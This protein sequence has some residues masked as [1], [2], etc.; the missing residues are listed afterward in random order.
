MYLKAL[1]DD[2][3]KIREY[4]EMLCDSRTTLID[5]RMFVNDLM[6][7]VQRIILPSQSA[8]PSSNELNAF[9]QS[10]CVRLQNNL[11]S[12]DMIPH[13]LQKIIEMLTQKRCS[14]ALLCSG[15]YL[16]DQLST[17]HSAAIFAHAN[18]I[19][20]LMQLF[21]HKKKYHIDL[22]NNSEVVQSSDQATYDRIETIDISFV[23]L[24]ILTNCSK[25]RSVLE[26][27][28]F[29]LF[30]WRT[31][32]N[33]AIP[34]LLCWLQNASFDC[35]HRVR[36]PLT[37]C[38]K[39]RF[40][41]FACSFFYLCFYFYFFDGAFNAD[42][43]YNTMCLTTLQY[44]CNELD[45]NNI[46]LPTAL[47]TLSVIVKLSPNTFYPKAISVKKFIFELLLPIVSSPETID[48]D[49]VMNERHYPDSLSIQQSKEFGLDVLTH[50]LLAL[51]QAKKSTC[52]NIHIGQNDHKPV[53][54]TSSLLWI[55]LPSQLLWKHVE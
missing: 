12:N 40:F 24:K 27:T 43:I 29:C 8:I 30:N 10:L 21:S 55:L 17:H 33:M 20:L 47:A 36:V 48:T 54:K 53:L 13:L 37:N 32:Q 44:C 42:S 50:Y 28:E 49:V 3:S 18:T 46:N 41:T 16:L 23:A 11:F 7:L 4:L 5:Q 22:K 34:K 25:L 39:L 15:V 38:V 6:T 14:K 45:I 51:A 2:N 52:T 19:E 26:P 1:F 31:M 9:A 35:S